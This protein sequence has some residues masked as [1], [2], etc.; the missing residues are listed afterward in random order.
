MFKDVESEFQRKMFL[1]SSFLPD[2][3]EN[4]I[5]FVTLPETLTLSDFFNIPRLFPD[6]EDDNLSQ[7]FPGLY[8]PWGKPF[9]FQ[10]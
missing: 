10:S 3:I 4:S 6:I 5:T 1:T 9:Y 8:E 2:L 7:T